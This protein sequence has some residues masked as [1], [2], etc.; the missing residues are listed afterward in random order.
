MSPK[1][2]IN[3]FSQ[4][5]VLFF[6]LIFETNCT[7]ES[8]TA[9]IKDDILKYLH[10][11]SCPA[12]FDTLCGKQ[13]MPTI[14]NVFSVKVIYDIT[15]SQLYFVSS[16]VYELHFDFCKK[17]LGYPKT[18]SLFNAEQ[19][20]ESPNRLY[21][22]AS[23]N[24]YKDQEIYTLEFIADDRVSAD[25]I[26]TLFYSVKN[27]V[28]F[29]DKLYFSVVSTRFKKIIDSIPDI[30]SIDKDNL[31]KN[32]IYQAL[33]LE[34]TYGW[35]KKISCK[36][37]ASSNLT[38]HDI[39]VTDNLPLDI[40]VIAGII[41]TEFQT[42]LSHINVLSHNRGTPNMALK[43]AWTDTTISNLSDKLVFLQVS[44]DSFTLR[45]ASLSE[46]GDFWQNNDPHETVIL[47][48][49]DDTSGLFDLDQLSHKSLHLVG[50]KAA[51][52]AELSRIN[53][54]TEKIT[55]PENGFAIPFYYYKQHMKS[56][57]IDKYIDTLLSDSLI[58]V[59]YQHRTRS[60]ENLRNKI[61]YSALDPV[62]VNNVKDKIISKGTYRKIRFRSSTNA[63][64]VEGF[65][66]AGLYDSH[67]A[68]LDNPDKSIETAIKNVFASLWTIRGFD[69]RDYFKID[70]RSVAMGILV[71]RS[72]PSEEAN[73]VAI[74]GNIYRPEIPAFTIS[75]QKGEIS[76]VQPPAGTI[77][78]QLLFYTFSEDLFENPSIEYITISNQ[79]S[80][81]PVMSEGEIV[82]LVKLLSTIK[83]HFYLNV[84]SDTHTSYNNFLMDVEF[85]LDGA[86][87]KLYIKQVRPYGRR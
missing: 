4:I 71:H 26:K 65:N 22:L 69:E 2:R 46:A 56:N 54:E 44:A 85:K 52:F 31:Y 3:S 35:L 43:N 11:I 20:S 15:T 23:I 72:F 18:H 38:R 81:T 30:P 36:D 32:Q 17:E 87:R 12:E 24:Y 9:I 64:D 1:C 77:P 60:L 68:D 33:N 62:F 57:G 10:T 58:Y 63:E 19:Y 25:G 73:G 27:S 61:R 7:N 29:S 16:S 76:V 28:F 84:F 37:L 66:G 13:F 6:F 45:E 83:R 41:T 59:N 78:D 51:N 53:I 55:V 40:P 67:T 86:D 42:P 79:N 48:C 8:S 82:Q 5:I 49:H 74:T 50:A 47:K 21:F 70:H 34:K 75:V 14:S 80:G 39:L